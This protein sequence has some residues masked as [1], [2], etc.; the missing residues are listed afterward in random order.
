MVGFP[1][2]FKRFVGKRFA[3]TFI[4]S[5]SYWMVNIGNHVFPV[6]KYRKIYERLLQS[7]IKKENI[8]PPEPA[9]E[10][11]VLRVHAPKYLRKLRSGKLSQSEMAALEIPP[12]CILTINAEIPLCFFSW[13]VYAYTMPISATSP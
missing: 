2:F 8:S 7:G 9:S 12:E 6:I 11:D 13:S 5:D 4:Y 10:A 1:R 3:F